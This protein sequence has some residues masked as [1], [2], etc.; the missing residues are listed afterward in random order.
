[1]KRSRRWLGT[2]RLGTDGPGTHGLG[3]RG[4]GTRRLSRRLRANPLL[5]L[6]SLLIGLLSLVALA[7]PWVA[8]A[9][10]SAQFDPVA[11]RYLPPGS[12]R[13]PL[14][15]RNG[16]RLLAERVERHGDRLVALRL[17]GRETY[18]AAELAGLP[19]EGVP[20]ARRFPLGTDRFGRDVWAR[21]VYG[22]RVS[23]AV[24]LLAV[25]IAILLGT[26]V[27][28]AA[29]MSGE[30][31]ENVLM[32]LVDALMAVPRLFLLLALVAFFGPGT[33]SLVAIIGL[34]IWMIVARLVR[35]EILS[36]QQRDF[37]VAARS[38]GAHPLRI[39]FVHLLPNALTTLLV[40]AG[41]MVG[42]VILLES[43]LSFLGLGIQPPTPSWGNMIGEASDRL[44]AAWWVST[45]PGLAIVL[46]VVGFNLLADGLRDALDPRR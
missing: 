23:L 41:L 2:H 28:A 7:A 21:L 4:F 22:A 27:G 10:P 15:F 29:A 6:G 37:V 12:E 11:G 5:L 33:A 36:L 30:L 18:D 34:T 26:A 32:R 14:V 24:A 9:D 8:G 20:A 13:I 31:V 25:L 16:R 46:T 45:F 38:L 42:A 1:M 19:A 44:L 39:L 40:L 35:A 43:S 17:G 3:T